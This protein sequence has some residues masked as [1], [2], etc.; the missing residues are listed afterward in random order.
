MSDDTYVM[1]FDHSD[2][3]GR[4]IPAIGFEPNVPSSHPKES[5]VCFISMGS[6]VDYE[7]DGINF[8]VGTWKSEQKDWLNHGAWLIKD[9]LNGDDACLYWIPLARMMAVGAVAWKNKKGV[10]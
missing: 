7:G 9:V 2:G 1:F 3:S 6:T 5:E 8:Y 4:L 10:A